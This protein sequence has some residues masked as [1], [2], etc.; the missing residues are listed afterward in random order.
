MTI[1]WLCTF[2]VLAMA[3]FSF[4]PA[5]GADKNASKAEQKKKDEEK[6]QHDQLL[7]SIPQDAEIPELNTEDFDKAVPELKLDAA[8]TEKI[9]K[10]KQRVGE[11]RT[12]MLEQQSTL[13][14]Q[15]EKSGPSDLDYLARKYL[16]VRNL[17]AKSNPRSEFFIGLV[18]I[19]SAEQ[20]EKL[21][22]LRIPSNT[23]EK[24]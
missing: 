18:N 9:D 24:R 14:A 4:A 21:K 1:R 20:R 11:K 2:S 19:L 23:S 16:E 12:K 13:R 17:C 15:C 3:C 7:A 22:E 5:Y 6:K 10:L 8:A